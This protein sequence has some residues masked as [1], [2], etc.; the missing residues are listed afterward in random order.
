M[1]LANLFGEIAGLWDDALWDSGEPAYIGE[2]FT[3]IG[4]LVLFAL[5]VAA[6]IF[7]AFS[8]KKTF[9]TT[10]ET[11]FMAISIALSFA[12]SYIRLFRLPQAGSVTAASILPLALYAYYFGFKKGLIATAIYG[13]LQLI[14]DPYIIHPLQVL[15]DYPLA[16]M[17]ISLAGLFRFI[18]R[19]MSKNVGVGL[20]AGIALVAIVRYIM[21]T[22][23]GV[24]FFGSFVYSLTYNSFV[25]VDAV[26][27]LAL[28][29]PLMLNKS[30]KTQ[31]E[32]F[33]RTAKQQLF[34]KPAAEADNAVFTNAE[35]IDAVFMNAENIDKDNN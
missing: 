25:F 8:R 34:Q 14:Q 4:S 28:S 22:L 27:A 26:I 24:L 31:F 19:K 15:L 11:T 12:L 1:I 17:S 32:N 3:L 20:Y 2:T 10:R 23:S 5:V 33:A 29:V 9:L 6:I 7:A 13:L 21:H 30:F 35:S 16:F 18:D